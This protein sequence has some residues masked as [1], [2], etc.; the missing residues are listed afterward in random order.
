MQ[1]S[2]DRRYSN[3][4]GAAESS[5]NCRGKGSSMIQQPILQLDIMI[6]QRNCKKRAAQSKQN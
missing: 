5:W 1:D 4:T 2:H 3:I 6:I